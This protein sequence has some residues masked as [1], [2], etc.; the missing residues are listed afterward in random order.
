VLG[1]VAEG[2]G[3]LVGDNEQLNDI[4]SRMGGSAS[5]IDSYLAS[6][7]PLYGLIAA[8]YAIQ[9]TLR[10]RTEETGGRAEPVLSTAVSRPRWTASHLVFSL[11]GPAAALVAAGL[12]TGLTHGLNTGD[13]RGEVPRILAGAVVQLPAVWT[14]AAVAVALFGL[15]PQFAA[16]SW[17]G[18]AVCLLLSLVGPAL[19]LDQ[20]VLDISPFAHIPHLPGGEVTALPLLAL[21]AVAVA[22]G[23]AGLAGFRRRDVPVS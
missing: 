15:L 19:Q 9:A 10:L 2:V 14:L 17:G 5:L 11:L 7:M 20:W 16:V 3:D 12:G 21:V 8:G 22:I 23:L 13:V 6:I 4:I 18:L 1:T